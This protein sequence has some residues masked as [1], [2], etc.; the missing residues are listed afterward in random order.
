MTR[1]KELMIL[2]SFLVV[3]VLL[4]IGFVEPQPVPVPPSGSGH[5]HSVQP[6]I[7]EFPEDFQ[8]LLELGNSQMDI[9]E[10]TVAAEAYSRALSIDGSSVDLRTD[11]G[12][13]L[14]GIGLLDRSVAEY[15]KVIE[16]D[17]NHAIV[18]YNLA[19]VYHDLNNIDSAKA[20]WIKYL[21]IEPEGIA[22]DNSRYYLKQLEGM[23]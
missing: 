12:T 22:A 16:I 17:P 14:Y 23:L 11:Y 21:K 19:I 1:I 15:M 18:N 6:E 10:Y 8:G 9:G 2:G 3:V 20:Y 7:S 4:F 5:N 13:C